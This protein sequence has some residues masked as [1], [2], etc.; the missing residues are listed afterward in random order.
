[1]HTGISAYFNKKL[2]LFRPGI[3]YNKTE[4]QFVTIKW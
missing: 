1:M 4:H 3:M 2:T